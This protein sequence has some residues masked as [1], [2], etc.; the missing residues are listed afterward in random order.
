MAH[1]RHNAEKALRGRSHRKGG[2]RISKAP[3][4]HVGEFYV[5]YDEDSAFFCLFNTESPRALSSYSD[6]GVAKGE[7]ARLNAM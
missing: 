2:A 3:K 4:T 6:E 5:D 7:A 1:T